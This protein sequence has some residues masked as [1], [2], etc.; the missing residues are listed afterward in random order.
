MAILNTLSCILKFEK[1]H[2]GR[3]T[4]HGM[5]TKNDPPLPSGGSI[6]TSCQRCQSDLYSVAVAIPA[7]L[8]QDIL[9]SRNRRNAKKGVGQAMTFTSSPRWL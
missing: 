8:V 5:A 1:I 6:N 9:E 4:K 2:D 7:S 3:V